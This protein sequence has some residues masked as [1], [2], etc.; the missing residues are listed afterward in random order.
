MVEQS[1]RRPARSVAAVNPAPAMMKPRNA[2]ESLAPTPEMNFYYPSLEQMPAE[3]NY[4]TAKSEQYAFRQRL[5]KIRG[6][7]FATPRVRS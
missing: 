3:G 4:S 1:K 7:G 5:A 2:A 6:L